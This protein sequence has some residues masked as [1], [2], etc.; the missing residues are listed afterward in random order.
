MG[1][2]C[3][4]VGLERFTREGADEIED[5]SGLR[6]GN[7]QMDGPFRKEALTGNPAQSR[8]KSR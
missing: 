7:V 2:N 4:V 3:E 5:K 1:W 8:T 6:K